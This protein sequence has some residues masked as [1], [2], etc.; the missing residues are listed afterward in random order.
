MSIHL[1]VCPLINLFV[2]PLFC[3]SVCPSVHPHICNH[4]VKIAKSIA[5]SSEINLQSI[6]QFDWN[7]SSI[8][9]KKYWKE[10]CIEKLHRCFIYHSF[11]VLS[12]V[13]KLNARICNCCISCICKSMNL[14]GRRRET[15]GGE[16]ISSVS[17]QLNNN[18]QVGMGNEAWPVNLDNLW[19]LSGMKLIK[20][21]I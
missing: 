6:V 18:V 19:A 2:C 12:N 11:C 1:L 21:G 9:W 8:E 17:C 5:K 16:Y 14:I 13:L 4:V 20:S 3:P 7:R 15:G 10:N